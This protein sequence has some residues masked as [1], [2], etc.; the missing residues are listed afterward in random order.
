MIGFRNLACQSLVRSSFVDESDQFQAKSRAAL[1]HTDT[2]M[3]NAYGKV[4]EDIEDL[5]GRPK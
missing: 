4:F 5:L 3:A 2:R 1:G